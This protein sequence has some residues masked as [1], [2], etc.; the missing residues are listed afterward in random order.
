MRKH[1]MTL[2]LRNTEVT[3]IKKE[4]EIEVTFE[5]P[6]NKGFNE[7]ILD[8]KGEIIKRD[9][10]TDSETAYFQRFLHMNESG[11]IE[12]F[13]ECEVETKLEEVEKQMELTDQRFSCK[14]VK[15]TLR[16]AVNHV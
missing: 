1:Y 8:M 5:Q 14:D 12:E 4:G 9:G 16:E 2:C 6:C 10:F 11:I 13:A 15:N 7:L 3:A